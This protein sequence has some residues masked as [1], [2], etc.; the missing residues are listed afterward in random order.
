MSNGEN[1]KLI[2]VGSVEL[3]SVG[4]VIPVTT[5]V[6]PPDDISLTLSNGSNSENGKLI[7]QF[8]V[9]TSRIRKTVIHWNRHPSNSR[10]IDPAD[11]V[12][13]TSTL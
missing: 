11:D 9:L 13:P 6:D 5:D 3:L 12:S 1:G 7:D 8:P 4:I 10:D 2:D